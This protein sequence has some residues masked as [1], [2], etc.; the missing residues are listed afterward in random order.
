LPYRG[1][2]HR[3]TVPLPADLANTLEFLAL[4]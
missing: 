4:H 3:W 2:K 1:K